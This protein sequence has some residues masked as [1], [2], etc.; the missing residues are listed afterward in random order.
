MIS[1]CVYFEKKVDGKFVGIELC[2]FKE[3]V[4]YQLIGSNFLYPFFGYNVHRSSPQALG[5]SVDK[6]QFITGLPEERSDIFNNDYQKECDRYPGMFLLKD[7]LDFDYNQIA[8]D[9][10]TYRDVMGQT[11]FDVLDAAQEYNAHRILF[12]FT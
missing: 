11:Y 9:S 7:A 3:E 12:Y 6:F 5:F 2:E 4:E 1:L 8:H 10:F